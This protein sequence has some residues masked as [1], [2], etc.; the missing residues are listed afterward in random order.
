MGKKKKQYD[1]RG[2]VLSCVCIYVVL[3]LVM[4]CAERR[5]VG[6]GVEGNIDNVI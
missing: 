1:V 2:R 4:V 5:D 6:G 3:V